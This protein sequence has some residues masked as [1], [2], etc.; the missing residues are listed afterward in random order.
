MVLDEDF[1]AL[2]EF[3]P[4]SVGP[5][6]TGFQDFLIREYHNLQGQMLPTHNRWGSPLG[7]DADV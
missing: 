2:G 5:G 4:G 1:H 7:S 3:G 6:R